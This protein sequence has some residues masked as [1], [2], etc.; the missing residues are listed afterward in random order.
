MKKILAIFITAAIIT[1][2][3]LPA[4]AVGNITE[5]EMEAEMETDEAEDSRGSEKLEIE[6]QIKP[7]TEPEETAAES[8]AGLETV[9]EPE[10][11]SEPETE[12]EA[13]SEPASET[14]SESEG[15]SENTSESVLEPEGTSE[16]I[17]ESVPETESEPE[18]TSETMSEPVPET[19]SEPEAESGME[20]SSE[21]VSETMMESTTDE[22][23][24]SI[25]DSVQEEL[26]RRE[27]ENGYVTSGY[28]DAGFEADKISV[29]QQQ[30]SPYHIL[31]S[32]DALP[33]SYS[34]VENG[35][36]SSVKDQGAWGT[37]WAF[38]A[39]S[40]AESSYKRLNGKEA[41]L[42][43]S[44]L[45][46]F[47]YNDILTGP[48]GGLEGDGMIPLTAPKTMQGG[49]NAFTTF[50]MASWIGIA[51]EALDKSLKY[52]VEESKNTKELNILSEYAYQ[53][54]LHMQN[55]YWI[56]KDNRD[57]IKKSVMEYG[58][59]SIYYKY[60]SY[61]D[62]AYVDVMLE[63]YGLEKYTG[64]AVYYYTS[65]PNEEGHAVSIVG[66]N[67]HFDKNNFAYT[68]INQQEVLAFKR[69]A[70]LPQNDGAWLIKNS[71][72]DDYGDAGY[73]WMSYE[74]ASLSET[75]F[76][77]DFENA[78]NYDHIYQYDGS[79]GVH[80]EGSDEG[81]TAA[82]VYTVPTDGGENV[83]TIES[84]GIGVASANTDY[85][86]KIYTDLADRT[87]PD[88]GRLRRIAK[89]STSFQGYYT[90][91]LE[92][93]LSL[94]GGE[95]YAVVV[96][97]QNGTIDGEKQ[98]AIFID[99]T[100]VN[101][102]AVRFQA[103]VHPEETF[104]KM[105]DTWA[106]AFDRKEYEKAEDKDG[107]FKGTYRIKAYSTDGDNGGNGDD[108]IE[109]PDTPDIPDTPDVWETVKLSKLKI[110]LDAASKNACYNGE[111]H[112][113]TVII[114]GLTEGEDYSVS[115]KNVVNAGKATVIVTGLANAKTGIRYEGTKTLSFTIKKAKLADTRL[116]YTDIYDYTGK[117]VTLAD[118]QVTLATD[119]NS[120]LLKMGRDYT[121][122]YKNNIKAGTGVATATIK[123]A[124][125]NFYGSKKCSFSI[126]P[127]SLEQIPE[128]AVTTL[129]YSSRGAKLKNI[130]YGDIVLT[131]GVDYKAKYTY[132]DKK[133]KSIGSTVDIV[134]T[135]KNACS[136]TSKTFH[137]VVIRK[138]DFSGCIV[139]PSELVFDVAKVKRTIKVKDYAGVTLKENKDYLLEWARD[140]HVGEQQ[141]LVIRPLKPEY[142]TGS[143]TLNYRIAN[144]IS[145]VKGITISDKQY[146]GVDP[147]EITAADI[148]GLEEGD[149]EVISYKNNMKAG[150]ATVVL[151]GAGKYYGKKT[152]QFRILDS[153]PG[154][155][156]K[157]MGL[158]DPLTEEGVLPMN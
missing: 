153:F 25:L 41:D 120:Y 101:A 119:N 84:V 98:S 11:V 96:S 70:Q 92:R 62:S 60:S 85:V 134:V 20:I 48:D 21:A 154:N 43:E 144:N 56:N 54:A 26:E 109:Q 140:E 33:A 18:D 63:K 124:N 88:S 44:H 89:G 76:A 77:F 104:R 117:P 118:L 37:C 95:T 32:E 112:N 71:W 4:N 57:E 102:N 135:G 61:N 115:Y 149:F 9:S 29:K 94:K 73:F 122:S 157:A 55:A 2:D 127:L 150:K 30:S 58:S 141:T 139:T 107:V 158:S 91:K 51:D 106:D 87:K 131:E 121:V 14:E 50:A 28:I 72:G 59:V 108:D 39:V 10:I 128:S 36:V 19:E 142:Y 133:T 65:V 155:R 83:Q 67:D 49:N 114:A 13:T 53:D 110:S 74:D 23:L 111:A 116:S 90:V 16:T 143:K 75:M 46:N 22:E 3:I 80:Y 97:L 42:S 27:Q 40:S 69:E 156:S 31:K 126:N 130:V 82:A 38:A 8:G 1:A 152:L 146:N 78:D 52:P 132:S 86:V 47:F 138:A 7:K 99:Q 123:A 5:N 125:T 79:A 24:E 93:S 34:A 6:T 148:N 100:Y 12:S 64:P 66:W 147:V 17:S 68:F 81:I 129:E 113:P 15:T 105:D 35:Q 103:A 136:K 145:K 137:N 151:Q 45:V